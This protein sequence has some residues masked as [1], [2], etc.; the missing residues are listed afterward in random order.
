MVGAG[1]TGQGPEQRQ[2]HGPRKPPPVP[3]HVYWRRR[4]IALALVIAVIVLLVGLVKGV[5]GLFSGDN[6]NDKNSS[7]SPGGTDTKKTPEE[8]GKSPKSCDPTHIALDLSSVKKSVGAGATMPFTVTLTYSGSE[9]CIVD[10]SP[11]EE[12]VVVYSGKDRIWSNADCDDSG[13]RAFLMDPQSSSDTTVN[14]DGIRS[15][16]SCDAD[17]P[18]VK[19]GTYKAVA[20]YGDTKSK[21]LVF[22]VQ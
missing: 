18:K 3:Q 15:N 14:W 6:K 7:A 11:S 19:A 1:G 21:E 12:V 8:E 16:K 10:T 20:S 17:L 9:A 13:T 22:T 2:G 5:V 4:I